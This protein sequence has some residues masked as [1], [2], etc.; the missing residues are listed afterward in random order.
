MEET[1]KNY[2]GEGAERHQV[3]T[4]YKITKKKT[5]TYLN[6]VKDLF[7]TQGELGKGDYEFQFQFDLGK[8]L[9]S[10]YSLE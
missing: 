3:T 1:D 4:K 7:T 2:E 5:D 6:M 9:P 8:Q 10:T